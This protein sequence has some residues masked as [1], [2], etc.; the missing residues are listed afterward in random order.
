MDQRA[1]EK[2]KSGDAAIKHREIVD[3]ILKQLDSHYPRMIEDDRRFLRILIDR[4]NRY[5][6]V[7]RKYLDK[8]EDVRKFYV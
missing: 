5:G 8:L 2:P 7:N 4:M 6:R 1:H 3:G